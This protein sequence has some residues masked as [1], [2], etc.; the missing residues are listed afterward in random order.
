[1]CS[2]CPLGWVATTAQSRSTFKGS[3]SKTTLSVEI[4]MLKA[5]APDARLSILT[6]PIEEPASLFQELLV[7]GRRKTDD[8]ELS[9]SAV[10]V[11]E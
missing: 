1:M 5:N 4:A 2:C 6:G 11:E 8:R 9:G 7:Q 3:R 10:H